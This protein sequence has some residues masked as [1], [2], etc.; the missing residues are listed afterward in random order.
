MQISRLKMVKVGDIVS[1]RVNKVG[2]NEVKDF[3]CE[4]CEYKTSQRYNLIR[5]ERA[6]HEKIKDKKC[7][8][9]SFATS[10][11][12]NLERHIKAVHLKI[13]DYKCEVCEFKTTEKYALSQHKKAVHEK[14][15]DVKC[16]ECNFSASKSGSSS[17]LSLHEW[18]DAF[19]KNGLAFQNFSLH[20][21]TTE[22]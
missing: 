1:S 5:H 3:R 16:K 9:C 4:Q 6:V 17:M 13:N 18:F 15:R 10:S 11:T 2:C 8:N 19:Q 21:T 12:D 14:I 20:P 7:N 22:L